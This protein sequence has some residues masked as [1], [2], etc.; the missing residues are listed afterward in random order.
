[1]VH[2]S[3]PVRWSHPEKK[4]RFCPP[5]GAGAEPDGTKQVGSGHQH[6]DLTEPSVDDISLACAATIQGTPEYQAAVANF[7]DGSEML[8]GTDPQTGRPAAIPSLHFLMVRQA[9]KMRV[10]MWVRLV[11]PPK[12]HTGAVAL[13][14]TADD[15]TDNWR[16]VAE[17]WIGEEAAFRGPDLVPK[18]T[19]SREII[20][21]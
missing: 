20:W 16:Y 17:C 3:I 8:A 13:Y 10:F 2:A 12:G 15:G 6:Q 1:M 14:T 7:L 21:H 11:N 19:C 18:A 5:L 9:G 4:R